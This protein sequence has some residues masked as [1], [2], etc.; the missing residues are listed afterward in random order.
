MC[1]Y[2]QVMPVLNRSGIFHTHF[3]NPNA[4][5]KKLKMN[6]K[7]L[8]AKILSLDPKKKIIKSLLSDPE[9]GESLKSSLSEIETLKE[10]MAS[11]IKEIKNACKFRPEDWKPVIE[12]IIRE[13]TGGDAGLALK[14][15]KRKKEIDNAVKIA[16]WEGMGPSD[17]RTIIEVMIMG[18]Q[19]GDTNYLSQYDVKADETSAD[20]TSEEKE[21]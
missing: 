9:L 14:T 11:I 5:V 7:A 2:V 12:E 8:L 18:M 19:P 15:W 20:E 16:L 13:Q 4:Y 6:Q 3:R 1:I 21:K 10:K 17:I